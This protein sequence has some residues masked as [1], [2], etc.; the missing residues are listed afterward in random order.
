MKN[1]AMDGESSATVVLA[2][3]IRCGRTARATV[4]WTPAKTARVRAIAGM[5]RRA[6]TPTVTPGAKAKPA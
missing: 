2:G 5:A 6:R 4:P 1:P 3:D